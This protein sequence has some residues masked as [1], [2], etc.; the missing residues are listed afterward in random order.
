[1]Q[2]DDTI[3]MQHAP[4]PECSDSPAVLRL[5]EPMPAGQVARPVVTQLLMARLARRMTQTQVA[6]T[7][8]V[9]VA[10]LSRWETGATVPLLSHVGVW[11]RAVGV[12]LL[13]IDPGEDADG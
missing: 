12:T 3:V 11:A 4:C 9:T 7:I 1:M 13:E 8:G 6:A 2:A 10:S 5:P